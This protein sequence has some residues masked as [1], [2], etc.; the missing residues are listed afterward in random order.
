MQVRACVKIS[1]FSSLT[2]FLNGKFGSVI[3]RLADMA[4]CRALVPDSFANRPFGRGATFSSGRAD[5]VRRSRRFILPLLLAPRNKFV[6]FWQRS[7]CG[8][9]YLS[10]HCFAVPQFPKIMVLCWVNMR[11]LRSVAHPGVP[12]RGRLL[13]GHPSFYKI[14]SSFFPTNTPPDLPRWRG[15]NGSIPYWFAVLLC[16]YSRRN[17]P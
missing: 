15:R 3:R 9:R 13:H 5:I 6:G 16:S 17:V 10:P 11:T 7:P 8:V 12:I 14:S 4:R 2:S 1:M